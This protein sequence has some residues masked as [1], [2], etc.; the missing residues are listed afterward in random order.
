MLVDEAVSE[1]KLWFHEQS[2]SNLVESLCNN[3]E[4]V[5]ELVEYH[6]SNFVRLYLENGKKKDPFLTFQFDWH[7]NCSALL[8][9]EKHELAELSLDEHP[10]PKCIL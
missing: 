3:G 10:V 4:L 5:E 6:Q 2:L 1:L 7:R 9:E 8:L